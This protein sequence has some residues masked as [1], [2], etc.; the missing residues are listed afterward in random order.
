MIFKKI[1]FLSLVGFFIMI[2]TTNSCRLKNNRDSKNKINNFIKIAKNEPV[3]I[4]EGWNIWERSD[5]FVFDFMEYKFRLLIVNKNK[6]DFLFKEIFPKQDSVFHSLLEIKSRTD[7]YPF[8]TTDFSDKV[9]LFKKLKVDQVNSI[10]EDSLIMFV[11][12]GFSIIYTQK[13]T[14]VRELNRYKGY[15]KYDCNWYYYLKK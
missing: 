8:R 5:G 2:A 9:F 11:N 4:F 14:D 3:E 12:E 13:V 7:H 10:N 1:Y 15:S 6:E